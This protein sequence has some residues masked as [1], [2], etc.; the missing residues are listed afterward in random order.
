M[1]AHTVKLPKPNPGVVLCQPFLLHDLHGQVTALL[2][3]ATHK[4]MDIL[5]VV[6]YIPYYG[7]KIFVGCLLTAANRGRIALLLCPFVLLFHI[8]P[9]HHLK[10]QFIAFLFRAL[11]PRL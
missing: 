1:V 2:I 3:V 5:Q 7:I 6:H 9:T 4:Q 11:V 10:A 8:R